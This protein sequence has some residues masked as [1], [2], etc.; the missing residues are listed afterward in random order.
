MFIPRNGVIFL[1]QE[2]EEGERKTS[3]YTRETFY[4]TLGFLKFEEECSRP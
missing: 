1:P 3:S 2:H 4:G